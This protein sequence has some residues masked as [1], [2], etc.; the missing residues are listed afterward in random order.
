M[1]SARVSII[2][3][4]GVAVLVVAGS[5]LAPYD[6][7]EQD[8]TRMLQGPGGAHW[9]GTDYLGRDVLS[10]LMAGT[11]ISVA[12]ALEAV[13]VAAAAGHPARARLGLARAATFEW[14]A[15]RVTDTL[16]VLPFTVFAI[17]VVGTLGNGLHQSMI[18]VGILMSPLF[19]RVTRAVTLGLRQHAVRR[20]GGADGR[21]RSGGSCASTSGRRCCRPSRSP[22]PRPSARPCC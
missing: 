21:Q 22:R 3:L 1:P 2:V 14:V 9:L 10:R 17:A 20:G 15:L 8:P 6:P 12:G 11:R 13:V 18:A 4:L 7:L 5:A 16:M 19:F